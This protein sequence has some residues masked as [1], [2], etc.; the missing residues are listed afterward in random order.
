MTQH[1]TRERRVESGRILDS[2]E[3]ALCETDAGAL[4]ELRALLREI[5]YET[6]AVSARIGTRPVR[7]LLVA[8]ETPYAG[9]VGDALDLAIRLLLLGEPAARSEVT[10]LLPAGAP[11]LL[12]RLGLLRDVDGDG[13]LCHA[14]VALYPTAGLYIV[15]DHV[16]ML[17]GPGEAAADVVYPAVADTTIDFLASLPATPCD[18]LLDLGAGT[19]IAALQA[20]A[21]YAGHAWA[22]DITERATRMARF[23]A[24]LNGLENVTVSCGDLYEPIRER[25]FDRIV[26]HPPYMP[27]PDPRLIF[28]DGGADGEQ[29]TRRIVEG[30]PAHLR[31]GGQLW[32]RFLGTDRKDA[33]LE[34][35]LRAMLGAAEV[36]FDVVVAMSPAMTPAEYCGRLLGLQGFTPASVDRQ[37]AIFRELEVESIVTGFVVIE[38]HTETRPAITARRRLPRRER[39]TAS[40][41]DWLLRWERAASEPSFGARLAA[42]R[43]VLQPH[44]EVQ[45]RHHMRAGELRAEGCAAVTDFPFPFRFESTP[46]AALLLAR[47]DGTRTVVQLHAEMTGLG[48][49]PEGVTL[50]QFVSLIYALVEGG[51]LEVEGFPLP[52]RE[53]GAAVR[54]AERAAG[55]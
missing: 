31:P 27:E 41:I 12:E 25:T 21:S 37:L 48:A 30:L 20:A 40:A 26:A 3:L 2:V 49:V 52:E 19:G 24:R 9:T 29:I 38:R 4:T 28:R 11:A 47:C 42:T 18:D 36:E 16:R 33:P 5:G 10:A 50:A 7:G 53:D 15:S 6:D 14:P 35:R 55:S 45:L 39:F 1:L 23:N 34:Q 17:V 54:G 32:C 22:A 51:V 46:G 8:R 43:P 44:A 13:A